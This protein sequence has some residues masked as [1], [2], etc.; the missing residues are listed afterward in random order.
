MPSPEN[1]EVDASLQDGNPAQDVTDW[2]GQDAAAVQEPA[3]NAA[4]N[5]QAVNGSTP[6]TNAEETQ[7]VPGEVDETEATAGPS[8]S[9]SNTPNRPQSPDSTSQQNG[10]TL[11]RK[12]SRSGSIIRSTS[13][14]PEST[15]PIRPRETPADKI[16]LEQYLNREFHHA[17]LM[18]WK[19]PHQELLQQKRAERDYYLSL[20]HE[21]QMNPGAIFGSGY[22]GYG[23][24]RTDLKSQHPQLLYPSNRRRPGGRKAKDLRI[25]R[26]DM[27]AQAEQ[28]EDLV[29][30][31]LDI[32]WDK[33]KLRDTFTWNL[34]DRVTPPDVFAER[35]VEDLGLPLESC[36]PLVRQISQ[37]IQEQLADFYPQVFMEEEPLDPHLPYHAYKNDEMRILIKLNI[38]IGQHTLV[39]QFE[40]EMNNPMNSPEEFA[41]QMTK[42]L[43]LT[44]EFTTA[45]AHSIRE[46]IQ[47][48]TKSLYI[49]SHP[50]DGRPIED[51]D[52]KSSFQPSPLPSPFRPFQSAKD[53]TPYLYELNE[54]ELERT[55]VSISRE[56]RRQKRSVNRRGGPALP[57]LK[58]RQ[59]TIRTLVVS[60]VIPG[61]AAS[62]EESRLFKRS[63]TSRSRRAA[64][65]VRDGGDD[66]DDSESDE[67]SADSPAISHLAQGT[68]RTRGMRGAASVAQAA[69]RANLGRSATPELSALQHHEPRG[70]ARRRDYRD[71]SSDVPDKLIV[72]LKIG[73]ERFRQYVRDVKS[74]KN[75]PA[76][77]A[78]ATTPTGKSSSAQPSNARS[79]M[80]PPQP[81]SQ[82]QSATPQ[83]QGAGT[84]KRPTPAQLNGVIDAPNPPQPGVPGPPPP[85]WLV[86]GLTNLSRSYPRDSFE[87]TMRYTAVD[88][89]TSLPLSSSTQ[90]QQQAGQ[91]LTY[92]YF[93][94]I[95]CHDCPGKLYTPGPAMTVDNFEVHLK[96]RQHKE[97]VEERW[98]KAEGRKVGDGEGGVGSGGGSGGRNGEED[99]DAAS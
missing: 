76:T 4:S 95:R 92:K 70:S 25:S 26:E 54:A 9:R 28:L 68:A 48:F 3:T 84:P 12:R 72:K 19:N 86:R 96:N 8:E 23:N 59:R 51:P 42:D 31:R 52:L 94:R 65:G 62:I 11:S 29:P 40:W 75:K 32:E 18:A 47:L 67:S 24:A 79:S 69:M 91:K 17:A 15:M 37:S 22:E 46:Q 56:Q 33:I 44:G 27:N 64:A 81:Q 43:S 55:E 2:T 5:G 78:A 34:H 83:Q 82:S 20:Q 87:G 99:E 50:F 14:P 77:P 89:Q 88:P 85:T 66:S 7:D 6:T 36:G 21:R 53:F 58:D 93:P 41:V 45:I 61:A 98:A 10:A 73:R 97:R 38:T 16:Q 39:D 90:Q 49:L 57:D 60:S 71:D 63:G 74:G 35:L 80:G 13:P 1:Q 30:I